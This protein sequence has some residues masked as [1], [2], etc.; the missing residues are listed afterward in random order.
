MSKYAQVGHR[1]ARCMT[2]DG[3]RTMVEELSR[4]RPQMGKK[5]REWQAR[6]CEKC[7]GFHVCFKHI[8]NSRCFLG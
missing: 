5:K 6:A 8:R 1:K 4:E 3:A 2:L 7:G